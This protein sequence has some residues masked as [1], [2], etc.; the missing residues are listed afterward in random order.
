MKHLTINGI[1]YD[2]QDYMSAP[3][4]VGL[5]VFQLFFFAEKVGDMKDEKETFQLVIDN[6]GELT[7]LVNR[8]VVKP[9]VIRPKLTT[10]IGFLTTPEFMDSFKESFTGLKEL[11]P[12]V[13]TPK[14][15]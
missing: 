15:V 12:T 11:F 8:L 3:D 14:K 6:M 2:V 7:R 1:L 9:K 10:I 13:D 4:M 5:N